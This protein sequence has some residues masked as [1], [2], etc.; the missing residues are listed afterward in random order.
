MIMTGFS[1]NVYLFLWSRCSVLGSRTG[2][3]LFEFQHG[4]SEDFRINIF[5]FQLL[6]I[7]CYI[8]SLGFQNVVNYKFFKKKNISQTVFE[9]FDK[10]HASKMLY[11]N[12]NIFVNSSEIKTLTFLDYIRTLIICTEIR[13]CLIILFP[14]PF[15]NDF[16][17]FIQHFG[18]KL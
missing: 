8:T 2:C 6:V 1:I 4:L 18:S 7:T 5:C 17:V 12:L 14:K 16:Q 13:K 3:C 9:N 10:M 15:Y 11:V